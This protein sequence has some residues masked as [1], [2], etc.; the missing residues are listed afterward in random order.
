VPF[1]QRDEL[2]AARLDLEHVGAVV[3][4]TDDDTWRRLGLEDGACL[5]VR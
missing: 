5:M 2:R 4:L 3:A 1:V